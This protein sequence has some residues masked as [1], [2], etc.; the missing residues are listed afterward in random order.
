MR[1][2]LAQLK[3]TSAGYLFSQSPIKS[4]LPPPVIPT[5]EFSPMKPSGSKPAQKRQF[6]R[7]EVDEL[8]MEK[9]AKANFWKGTA[10]Q[11]QAVLVMQGLYTGRVRKQLQAK[12]VKQ[13][14]KTNLKVTR[15]GLGRVLTMPELMEETAAIEQAQEQAT[16]EKDERRQARAD[17]AARL[18]D[19]KAKMD[20]RDVKNEKHKQSWVD[21]VNKWTE[22]RSNA[23]A[24]GHKL[25]DWDAKNPKPKRKAPEFCDLPKI[26]K[27][28]AA[29]TQVEDNECE[30]IAIEGIIDSESDED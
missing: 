6:T 9:E 11:Q 7:E 3:D 22:A 28:K 1:L 26:P 12:E 21:A 16:R 8:L 24:A 14:K 13:G 5:I 17:H 10:M 27:P 4:S 20:E 23:K 29:S 30:H 18:E 25:K 15:D 2:A 19:W